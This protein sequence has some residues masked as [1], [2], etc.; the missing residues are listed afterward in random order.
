MTRI[1]PIALLALL[2]GGLAAAPARAELPGDAEALA[3]VSDGRIMWDVTEPRALRLSNWLTMVQDT[4]EGLKRLGVR[5]HMV[6]IF[7]GQA[8]RLL[9]RE[10]DDVPFEDL[11]LID[12]VHAKLAELRRLPRVRLEVCD[13]ALRRQGMEDTPLVAGVKPVTNGFIAMA[14]YGAKGY[15]RVPVD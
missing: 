5:P 11:G 14:G 6:L 10:V 12:E 9:A 8:V 7:R 4:Y 15:T 2:L 13:I 1:L 3:G